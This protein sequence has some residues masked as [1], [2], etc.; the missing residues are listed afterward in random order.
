VAASAS[1]SPSSNTFGRSLSR[2]QT[3]GDVL[4]PRSS[5]QNL[6]E[7]SSSRQGAQQRSPEHSTNRKVKKW[8]HTAFVKTGTNRET[9]LDKD[10]DE[11]NTVE[12]EQFPAP[13]AAGKLVI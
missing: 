5:L 9:E 4:S 7:P 8:D 2:R 10:A 1:K 13:F 3:I 11:E 12:F 6:K